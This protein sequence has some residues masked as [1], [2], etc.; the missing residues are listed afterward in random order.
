MNITTIQLTKKQCY[1]YRTEILLVD[2]LVDPK[3]FV[4][5]TYEKKNITCRLRLLNACWKVG[6]VGHCLASAVGPLSEALSPEIFGSDCES[7]WIKVSIK[8]LNDLKKHSGG[9]K[10]GGVGYHLFMQKCNINAILTC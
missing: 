7:L 3:V 6:K 9:K 10:A 5:E 4:L 8:C 1:I 2:C